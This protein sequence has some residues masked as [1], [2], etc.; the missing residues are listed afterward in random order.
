MEP[1]RGRRLAAGQWTLESA[2]ERRQAAPGTFWIP[3]VEARRSL[4]VGQGVKLLFWI[5]SADEDLAQCERMW[6]VVTEVTKDGR[7]GG[8]LESTPSTPGGLR[9]GTLVGFGPEHVADIYDGPTG[10]QVD[11]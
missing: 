5:Q 1:W 10:D 9:K 4:R 8:V 6:V 7:Y 2:E 3:T 11:R